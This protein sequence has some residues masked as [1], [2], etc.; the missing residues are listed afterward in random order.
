M[1]AR[2]YI[3]NLF[4]NAYENNEMTIEE[5]K[6]SIENAEIERL[7]DPDCDWEFLD[8]LTPEIYMEIWNE[9]YNDQ[10]KSIEE[11]SN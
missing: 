6:S 9:L 1:T 11:Y 8:D 7:K 10:Q 3:E 5:A 2:E 4:D